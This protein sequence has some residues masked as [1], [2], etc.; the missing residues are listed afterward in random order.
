MPTKQKQKARANRGPGGPRT[1]SRWEMQP[2]CHISR[3]DYQRGYVPHTKRQ[4]ALRNQSNA[5]PGSDRP[6]ARS[7]VVPR[8]SGPPEECGRSGDLEQSFPLHLVWRIYLPNRFP[9]RLKNVRG[10]AITNKRALGFVPACAFPSRLRAS[11]CHHRRGCARSTMATKTLP[12]T[13]WSRLSVCRA[14]TS[15]HHRRPH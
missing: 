10:L 9:K 15:P 7:V 8:A 12:S 5:W 2:H 14:H 4:W 13:F 1:C 3:W 11:H 6:T